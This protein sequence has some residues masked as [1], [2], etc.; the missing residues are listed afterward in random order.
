MKADCARAYPPCSLAE[1]AEIA[2][3]AGV[4]TFAAAARA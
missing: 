2:V 1:P 4:G 3:V